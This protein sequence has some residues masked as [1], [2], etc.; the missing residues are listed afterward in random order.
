MARKLATRHECIHHGTGN[1][2]Q[3]H[4][5]G[6]GKARS[7]KCAF[8]RGR[9]YTETGLYG[10]FAWRGDGRYPE[11]DAVKTFTSPVVA[12]RYAETEYVKYPGNGGLVVRWIGLDA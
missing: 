8:C 5:K 12:D 11:A 10:V 6:H 3:S 7:Q 4:T 1:G 2:G 9:I